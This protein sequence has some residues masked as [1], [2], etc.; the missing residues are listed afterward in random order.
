MRQESFLLNNNKLH[1]QCNNNFIAMT[2]QTKSVENYV[3]KAYKE[4]RNKKNWLRESVLN[5]KTADIFETSSAG[6][7]TLGDA[8]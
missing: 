2:S 8:S 1:S 3:K 5:K 4:N 7:A 6:S